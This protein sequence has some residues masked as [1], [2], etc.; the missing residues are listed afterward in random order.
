MSAIRLFQLSILASWICFETPKPIEVD[1]FESPGAKIEFVRIPAGKFQ[2]GSPQEEYGHEAVEKMHEV[3]LS[4]FYLSRN[5]VSIAEYKRVMGRLPKIERV[6]YRSCSD[7]CPVYFVSWFDAIDFCNELSKLDG[8]EIAYKVI[9]TEF[10]TPN[11]YRERK[12]EIVERSSGY[13]L[14]TEAQW[15]YACRSGSVESYSFGDEMKR[16]FVHCN[17]KPPYTLKKSNDGYVN[18]MGIRNMHG[19]LSEWCWDWFGEYDES[20]LNDPTGPKTGTLR[21]VRG[22]TSI[23][24]S[25]GCRSASRQCLIPE[26]GSY[27]IGIRV[28]LPI[29]KE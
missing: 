2:M 21:I 4:S 19:N 5:E 16:D 10:S 28:C 22:G 24:S 14:P 25:T 29:D 12:V 26:V 13:R 3:T 7:S 20:Q 27:E 18:K 9:E 17:D 23:S 15:E 11:G 6:I 8:K 1:V